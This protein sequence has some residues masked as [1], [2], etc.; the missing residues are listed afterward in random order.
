MVYSWLT[1]S[2]A[3]VFRCSVAAPGSSAAKMAD[4]T[5][6]P[7]TPHPESSSTLEALMPPM[8]TTGMDTELLIS[9]NFSL[10]RFLAFFLV[11]VPNTAPT[12]I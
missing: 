11:L 9:F 12:P 8:A 7:S 4:T 6:T 1:I 5:A 2:A 10:E 3:S